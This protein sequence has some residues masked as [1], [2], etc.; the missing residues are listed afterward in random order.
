MSLIR[1]GVEV[2]ARVYREVGLATDAADKS[3]ALAGL[4][5]GITSVATLEAL[6]VLVTRSRSL[7]LPELGGFVVSRWLGSSPARDPPPLLPA[8]A[9]ENALVGSSAARGR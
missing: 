1:L 3:R 6:S 9:E 5:P 7:T 4:P 8:P 2:G